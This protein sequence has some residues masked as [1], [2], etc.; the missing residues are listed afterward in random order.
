MAT[1]PDML[2]ALS[3]VFPSG[4]SW[5]FRT[6]SARRVWQGMEKVLDRDPNMLVLGAMRAAMAK[7]RIPPY[8]LT[9]EDYSTLSMAGRWK[10]QQLRLAGKRT[11]RR[12]VDSRDS[13]LHPR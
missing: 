10:V 4:P 11:L 1:L 7:S 6:E 13:V 8:E 3:D 9:A 5:P 2:A 12:D